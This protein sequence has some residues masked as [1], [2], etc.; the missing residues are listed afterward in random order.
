QRAAIR[1]DLLGGQAVNV[2]LA[3]ADQQL[4]ELVE[5]LEVVGGV[6]EVGSPVEPEPAD[7]L[8]DRVDVLD[9]LLERVRVVEAKG[10]D[11]AELLRDA[12]VQADGLGVS[13]VEVAV[14]LGW[15]PGDDAPVLPGV[16]IVRDDV[17]D[18]I[19]RRGR[20]TGS[21]RVVGHGGLYLAD[22]RGD[23]HTRPA[24]PAAHEALDRPAPVSS[25]PAPPA[26]PPPPAPD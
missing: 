15:E 24:A 2:R 5:A 13:D 17:T 20:R 6:E 18:E 19:G 3:V 16:E 21:V 7:V 10:A 1:A 8:L 12:E 23:R 9:V 14:R 26:A 11:A 25:R 22:R 4:G